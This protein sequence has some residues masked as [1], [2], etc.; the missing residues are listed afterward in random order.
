MQLVINTD[1][2]NIRRQAKLVGERQPYFFDRA[3]AGSVNRHPQRLGMAL[4]YK[5][6]FIHAMDCSVAQNW[7]LNP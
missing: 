4:P 1:H 5:V 2:Y 7:S 3:L 6:C